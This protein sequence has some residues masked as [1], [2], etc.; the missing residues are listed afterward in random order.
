ML[1]RMEALGLLDHGVEGGRAGA[2][3]LRLAAD[4]VERDQ[5]DIAIE[6][7]VL[8]RLGHHRPGQ[9]LEVHR[10]RDHVAPA[11]LAA[12]REVGRERGVQEIEHREIDEVARSAR[13]ADRPVEVAPVLG[14]AP[15]AVM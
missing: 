14:L 2:E 3:M 1:K 11:I 12:V 5:A 15:A 6:R 7:G 13:L 4:L 10:G 9:L 8:D